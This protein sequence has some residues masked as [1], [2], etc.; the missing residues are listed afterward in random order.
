MN[1]TKSWRY[2]AM[3]NG[4]SFIRIEIAKQLGWPE[5]ENLEVTFK[6]LQSEGY[7]HLL[8]VTVEDDEYQITCGEV[9]FNSESSF[10]IGFM[11]EREDDVWIKVSAA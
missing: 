9:V 10:L 11:Q 8:G 7:V 1:L 4:H 6:A 5:T 3:F 2:Y